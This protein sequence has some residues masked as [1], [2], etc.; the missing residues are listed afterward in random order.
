ME[1]KLQLCCHGTKFHEE[2]V[3]GHKLS[4]LSPFSV[5]FKVCGHSEHLHP[6]MEVS[7]PAKA[8]RSLPSS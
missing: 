4:C 7:D 2:I 5:F 3:A 8:L 1:A 6:H